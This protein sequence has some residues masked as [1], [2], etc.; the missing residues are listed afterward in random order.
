M[1]DVTPMLA[2]YLEIKG[3]YQD[4]ILFYHIGDFYEMFYQDAIDASAILDITLTKKRVGTDV[5]PAPLCG[6][7]CHSAEGYLARLL[8]AGRKVAVCDQAEDPAF[9][10]G[11]VRREVTRVITPGTMT[12]ELMLTPGKSN[13]LASVYYSDRGVGL[14]YTDISTGQLEAMGFEGDTAASDERALLRELAR[15]EAA[16]I[17]VG[18][19]GAEE[20]AARAAWLEKETGAPV[21]ALGAADFAGE[22]LLDAAVAGLMSYLVSL[23]ATLPNTENGFA[24]HRTGERMLVGRTA[25]RNLELTES[26]HDHSVRGSLL[27][28]LDRTRTA[29]G[30]RKLKSWIREPL[31]RKSDIDARH[32]AVGHLLGAFLLRNDI[33]ETLKSVYDVERLAGRIDAGSANGRDLIS[34]KISISALPELRAALADTGVPLLAELA[35]SMRDHGGLCALIESALNEEQPL[36]T[37]GG[38]VIRDGYSAQID[39]LKAGISDGKNWIAE[40]ETTE[41]ERTGIKSLKVRYN[42]VQGYYIEITNSNLDQAPADYVRKQTLAGAERFVTPELKR[43]EGIVFAAESGIN[44]LEAEIFDELRERAK[45][46]LGTIRAAAAAIA[47][48]D[49]L[50]S[51]AQ[52]AQENGYTRPLVTDGDRILIV[53]GRHP[54]IER[55]AFASGGAFV[56]NDVGLDLADQSMLLVT[57][58]NMAGKSTFMRQTAIIVLMAQMGSF[59]PADSAEI[60]ICDRIFTRIGASDNIAR[61]QSTFLVEMNELADIIAEYTSRSL[62]ILDEIG[63]GTSTYDGLAIAWAAV[64]YLCAEGQR[65]RTMF[66]THYHELTALEGILPGFVNLST[67]VDDT[68]GRVV[69]LHKVAAGRASRSYGIHV[70]KMA[71]L[72]ESLLGDAAEK[73]AAL[74]KDAKEIRIADPAS[75]GRQIAF[76]DFGGAGRAMPG[77]D[78][79]NT[80]DTGST[81][82]GTGAGN[83][84]DGRDGTGAGNAGNGRDGTGAGNAEDAAL[85]RAARRAMGEL[86]GVDVLQ[87]TPAAAIALVEKL[88]NGMGS[89]GINENG[90]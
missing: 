72:P 80:G 36:S 50:V 8:A 75:A 26:M 89:G 51:L 55:M 40:L 15:V 61:E 47:G 41:R 32:D 71:G 88:K 67:Q 25:A 39:G 44:A 42:R 63:R 59:V 56:P 29:M 68:G 17:I 52:A 70:A 18:G 19:A 69:Y 54:V 84:R 31:A 2:Q 23:K 21:S 3:Q 24:V 30:A 73:L 83:G 14:A 33:R 27:G 90:A 64:D 12:S 13:F 81:R 86:E 58:P 49:A 16:E 77:G 4:C 1:S 65:A 7:P 62:I 74:E 85:L 60:G 78:A 9:T 43:I 22:T 10:K 34:L 11:I 66:A 48:L 87:L 82:D 46:E 37:H 35:A 53:R 79:G 45:A 6:V 5:E 57:G 76:L 28:V 38:G 20:A